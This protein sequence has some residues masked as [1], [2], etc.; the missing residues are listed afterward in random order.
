[1]RNSIV[2]HRRREH[3][4]MKR[5]VMQLDTINL[6]VTDTWRDDNGTEPAAGWPQQQR[7]SRSRLPLFLPERRQALG[8]NRGAHAISMAG[9]SSLEPGRRSPQLKWQGQRRYTPFLSAQLPPGRRAPQHKRQRNGISLA[10]S[11]PRLPQARTEW[12][13]RAT[14]EVCAEFRRISVVDVAGAVKCRCR[15]Q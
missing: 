14:D 8:S 15:A 5:L 11:L 12:L 4:T 7:M 1:M 6:E 13:E 10:W 9:V 2:C 3:V